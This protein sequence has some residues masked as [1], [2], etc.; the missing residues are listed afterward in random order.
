V[1]WQTSATPNFANS[2]FQRPG[3]DYRRRRVFA[4]SVS[5]TAQYVNQTLAA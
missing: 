3:S 1:N 2:G 5:Y 4:L